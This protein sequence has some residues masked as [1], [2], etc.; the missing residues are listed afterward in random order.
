MVSRKRVNMNIK[1]ILDF[2]IG[3]QWLV[4]PVAKETILCR[5]SFTQEHRDIE[6]M[7]L[8]FASE[9]IFPN[10]KEI[11]KLEELMKLARINVD[12]E[13]DDKKIV[14]KLVTEE[15]E[16]LIDWTN[17]QPLDNPIT[18]LGD[19]HDGIWNVISKISTSTQRREIL[20]WYHLKENIYKIL[21]DYFVI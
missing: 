11:E 17:S 12:N 3:G 4:S 18:C 13:D 16:K 9:R 6:K 14:I 10:V 8:K 7:V 5:E 1:E 21:L 19:G 20:D 15:N 2:K